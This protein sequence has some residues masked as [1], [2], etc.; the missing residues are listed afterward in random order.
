MALFLVMLSLAIYL[1]TLNCFYP[2]QREE[3]REIH[4]HQVRRGPVREKTETLAD[5]MLPSR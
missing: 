1:T 3:R 4:L 2:V 5:N